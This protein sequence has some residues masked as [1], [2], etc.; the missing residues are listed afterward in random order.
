MKSRLSIAFLALVA[1]AAC[2][3]PPPPTQGTPDDEVAIRGLSS[4][5]T[6]AFNANDVA[7]MARLVSEDFECVNADGTH[8]RGRAAFQQMEEKAAKDRQAGPKLTL[9]APTS[10]VKWIS[11]THAVSGGPWTMTGPPAPATGSWMAVLRK[12]PEGPWQITNSLVADFVP[13]A[14]ADAKG[15]AK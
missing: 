3:P 13:P 2:A 11:A 12:T 9:A 1:A 8:I 15:K 10:Y 6:D 4:K 14:L 5:Y 7:G